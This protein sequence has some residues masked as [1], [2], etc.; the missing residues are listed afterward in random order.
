M[1]EIPFVTYFCGFILLGGQYLFLILG[2]PFIAYLGGQS[3]CCLFLELGIL[4]V[5]YFVL[6]RDRNTCCLF[7][8]LEILFVLL[9]R[10][11]VALVGILFFLNTQIVMNAYLT[12]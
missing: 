1:L 6:L 12:T 7:F 9:G 11:L 4:F 3:S 5:A 8:V 2:I 10:F